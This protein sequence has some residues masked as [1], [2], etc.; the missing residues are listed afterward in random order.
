MK[1]LTN[2]RSRLYKSPTFDQIPLKTMTEQITT[3]PT[4]TT[5]ESTSTIIAGTTRPLEIVPGNS[6][7]LSRSQYSQLWTAANR[8]GMCF[9]VPSPRFIDEPQHAR[10][11]QQLCQE[12][13]DLLALGLVHDISKQCQEHV[14]EAWNEQGRHVRFMCISGMAQVMFEEDKKRP[15]N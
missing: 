6:Y 8:E 2:L 13:D 7:E 5:T 10:D 9:Q 1:W 12:F 14:E 4:P 11:L 15:V 3:S